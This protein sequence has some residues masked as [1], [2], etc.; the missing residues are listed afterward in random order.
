MFVV[1]IVEA[2]FRDG[3]FLL[4]VVQANFGMFLLGCIELLL[5]GCVMGCV[6]V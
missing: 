6:V 2:I 1:E 3:F 5:V 4:D